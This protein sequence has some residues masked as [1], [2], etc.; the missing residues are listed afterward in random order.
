MSTESAL[1]SYFFPVILI[2]SI[3]LGGFTGVFLGPITPY[4]RPFGEIFLNLIFTAIVPLI[5]F[6][7]TSAVARVGSLGKFGKI[8]FYMAIIFLFTGVVAAVYALFIVRLFPPAQGVILPLHGPE[9]TS[10]LNVFNQIAEIFT[11]PEFSQLLSHKHILAL[12][13]FSILVGL[14]TAN[15][16]E[17]GKTF[18]AFLQAGEEIFMRVFALIM[19][20]APFGFFAYFAV[21]VNELGP[22]LMTNYL[23]IGVLY[24]IFGT[25]YFIV[26]YTLFAYFAGKTEG[27]KRFWSNIF[28]PVVTSIATCSSAASI[29][30]NLM[31]AKKMEIAPEVYETVIPLGTIIHKDGS[32]I[33]GVFKIAFLFGIFHLNFSSPS[34]LLTAL[35]ISLLVGTVMGAIPSGGMLGELLILSAYGFPP[36][37]LIIIAA[38]SIIIDPLAT[39]LNVTCNTVSSMMIARLLEGKQQL[40]RA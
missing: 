11:V 16:N 10:A 38:I 7:I 23:R 6:S 9:K 13:L 2:T 29:P 26:V 4:L 22:Q 32:V 5:F 18:I 33:G 20:Y 24:Y 8:A 28:L 30:A 31:T 25:I 27:I 15:S 19:Y 1:K 40:I 39:M 34:V 17:K 21:L 14:S 37:V 12:I 36:S 35:G 3:L